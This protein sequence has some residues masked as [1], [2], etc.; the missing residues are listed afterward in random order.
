MKE[1]DLVTG[2][3][4]LAPGTGK[5]EGEAEA[6]AEVATDGIG[7]IQVG[8]MI[9][10]GVEIVE[11]IAGTVTDAGDPDQDPGLRLPLLAPTTR[12]QAPR[13]AA[14]GAEIERVKKTRRTRRTKKRKRC[15]SSA[16]LIS[17]PVPPPR[18]RAL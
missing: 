13:A 10:I 12:I 11:G 9:E 8:T 5:T 2:G 18:R 15:T 3:R 4:D 1:A 14:A 16:K 6:G 7:I 17:L